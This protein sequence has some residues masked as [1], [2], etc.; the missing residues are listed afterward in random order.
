MNIVFMGTPDFAVP[1]LK[2]LIKSK[3]N[4]ATV[5]TQTDKPRGRKSKP[6]A[7]PIKNVALDS[8]LQALQPENVN[9][10]IITEKLK[11]INPDV[12]VVVA[13][14][15]KISTKILDL[16][17]YKCINCHASLLPKYRGAA[18]IN[19][20][21]AKGEEET[22]ITTIVMREKMDAGEIIMQKSIRIEPEETS[23]EL[24][25]R[26]SILSAAILIDSLKLIETG[27]VKYTQQDEKAV[28]YAPKLKKE[29]GLV[30]WN[31]DT[32]EIHNHVR[33]MNPWPS[34]YTTLNKSD[35]KERIIILKTERD[36]PYNTETIENPGTIMDISDRGIK[37][38]TKN[39]C[40]WIKEIKPEGKQ[41]MSAGAFSR[42]HDVKVGYLFS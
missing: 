39:G 11:E 15:Q 29:N 10:K 19:W 31:R 1:S 6:C 2:S 28:T 16:P 13:F 18:P 17:K 27:D 7:P 24:E 4:V 9:D 38:A 42:G 33:A 20:A 22:G 35:S 32:K 40:I 21:I 26:L 5:I 3:Y 34:A 41:S 12:I 37:T 30:N 25:K 36:T 8:G 14:G 23:G